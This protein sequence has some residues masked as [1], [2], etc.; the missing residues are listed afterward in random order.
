MTDLKTL[1]EQRHSANNFIEGVKI[2]K[3]DFDAIF[4]LLKLAP[5]CFNIQ[6]ANYLVITDEDKKEALR[7]AAFNQYKI[8]TASAAV[9]VLGDKEAYKKVD[10]IYSGMLNLKMLSKIDYDKMM[11]DVFNLYEGRGQEFQR[12]EA[13]RNASLS[14]MMFMMIAKDKGWDTCPMIGFDNERVSKLFNIPENLE[15]VL[16]I[17]MGKED[18]SKRRM[19]GYRRPVGEFVTFETFNK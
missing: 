8:H 2:P 1:I 17:T 6:H 9:L 19:R 10:S 14:A 3:E 5:S 7:E 15:P 13:I 4:D 11:N 12:D 16:L 18:T